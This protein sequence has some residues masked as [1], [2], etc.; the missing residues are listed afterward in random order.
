MRDNMPKKKQSICIEEVVPENT[1]E[2]QK[3]GE[4]N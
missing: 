1:R 4:M 2:T 3:N